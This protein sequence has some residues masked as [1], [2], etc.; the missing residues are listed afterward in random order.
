MSTLDDIA[1]EVA[2]LLLDASDCDS[3]YDFT[4]WSKNDLKHYAKDG[5]VMLASLRPDWFGELKTITLQ[6][7]RVQ[8]ISSTCEKLI[9][10]I[11]VHG[12]VDADSPIAST[13]NDRLSGVFPSK[14]TKSVSAKD[15]KLLDYTIESKSDKIFYVNPPVPADGEVKLDVIC[16]SVPEMND[17]YVIPNKMHNL[18]VE[19]MLYRAY[20]AQEEVDGAETTASLHLNYFYSML[21]SIQQ[22][23]NIISGKVRISGNATVESN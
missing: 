11:G 3:A 9:K 18:I 17:D 2:K 1:R 23:D 13:V 12:S 16:S 6:P 22:A 21:R 8:Q 20:L 4:R 19:W 10:V 7:G 14:C 15:Y 5:I